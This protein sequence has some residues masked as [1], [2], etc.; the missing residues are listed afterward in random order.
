MAAFIVHPQ[1]S[2]E[3]ARL[4]SNLLGQLGREAVFVDNL[5]AVAQSPAL[6]GV[7]ALVLVPDF[8]PDANNVEQAIRFADANRHR[9]FIVYI[10]D[11]ITADHYKALV[12]TEAGDWVRWSGLAPE[13]LDVLRRSQPRSTAPTESAKVVTFMGASGGVGNTTLAMES[14]VH[15][16]SS[17]GKPQRICLLDL[18]FQYS[19]VAEYLDVEPRFAIGEIGDRAERIDQQIIDLFTTPHG[20]G[21]HLLASP[22]SRIDYGRINE[23]VIF[24]ILDF[25]ARRYDVVIVDMPSFWLPWTANVI[26][27]CD[28]VV[29]TG[30]YNIV[31]VK[32][33]VSRL[34]QLDEIGV[35][36]N[37]SAVAINQ[38]ATS[39]FGG[40]MR[41]SDVDG[42]LAGR[43]AF[44]VQRDIR[45]A[46]EAVNTGRPM[47]Q[48]GP[49]SRI[50]KD[51][52][53][54]AGWLTAPSPAVKEQTG[55]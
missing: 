35:A 7:P 21:L 19:A 37:R 6:G 12:R 15:L 34:A 30:A 31:S 8:G 33:V 2:D 25:I 46:Q 36:P 3:R 20:S 24:A 47:M 18:N 16:A 23:Q 48:V 54:V 51:I 11:S 9:A 50:V 4:L 29:V 45:L 17:K 38:C 42:A 41:R 26:S 53:Q 5:D 28:V 39:L 55:V 13:L 22:L 32:H 49:K 27:G 10:A 43:R 52:R 14:G 1:P 44:Y 40:I